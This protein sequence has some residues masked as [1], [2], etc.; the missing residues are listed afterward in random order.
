[1]TRGALALPFSGA[2]GVFEDFL[3]R[4]QSLAKVVAIPFDVGDAHGF[5]G[6]VNV[7]ELA[8]DGGGDGG[9]PGFGAVTGVSGEP[10][11]VYSKAGVPPGFEDGA[12]PGPKGEDE[13]RGAAKKGFQA[14]DADGAFQFSGFLNGEVGVDELLAGSIDLQVAGLKTF[15]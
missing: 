14:A 4:F 5:H 1:M 7:M 13:S 12:V 6:E 2:E 8:G 9:L 15:G 3:V 10:G 11:A